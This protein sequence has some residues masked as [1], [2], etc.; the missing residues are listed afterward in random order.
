MFGQAKSLVKRVA[1]A[2]PQNNA[3]P[4]PTSNMFQ[5]RKEQRPTGKKISADK[6][7]PQ[8]GI[9]LS[10]LIYVQIWFIV[11]LASP[12][13]PRLLPNAI[14]FLCTGQW[15]AFQPWLQTVSKGGELLKNL[16]ILMLISVM[17]LAR[18]YSQ[19]KDHMFLFFDNLEVI[20]CSKRE[21]I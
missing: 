19:E 17:G 16:V 15:W 13:I 9:T 20:S 21:K 12:V 6:I 4:L 3:T 14:I 1:T 8:S 18:N 5:S 7:P 11:S 2:I 10:E